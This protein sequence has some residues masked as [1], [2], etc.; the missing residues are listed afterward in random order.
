VWVWFE[1]TFRK[2]VSPPSSGQVNNTRSQVSRY[3]RLQSPAYLWSRVRYAPPKRRFKPQPHD[4]TSRKTT[5]FI[6][7]I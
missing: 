3:C 6:L 1:P 2:N 4:A 7:M 5:F